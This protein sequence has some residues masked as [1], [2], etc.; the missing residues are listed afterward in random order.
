MLFGYSWHTLVLGT[1]QRSPVVCDKCVVSVTI[2]VLWASPCLSAEAVADLG[3][4]HE[5]LLFSPDINGFICSDGLL[6]ILSFFSSVDFLG[7]TY[8][9]SPNTVYVQ[10]RGSDV[11]SLCLFSTPPNRFHTLKKVPTFCTWSNFNSS[12]KSLL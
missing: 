10:S 4:A 5:C 2:I 12:M 11:M 8:L 7:I 1:P 6:L 3:C 9:K